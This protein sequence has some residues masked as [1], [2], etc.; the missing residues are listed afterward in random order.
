MQPIP[1]HR[2]YHA[3]ITSSDLIIPIQRPESARHLTYYVPEN[4]T[5]LLPLAQYEKVSCIV[6]LDSIAR[7]GASSCISA[8]TLV[9]EGSLWNS[10]AHMPMG[11]NAMLRSWIRSRSRRCSRA[12]SAMTS[13]LQEDC[14]RRRICRLLWDWWSQNTF[15]IMFE[16]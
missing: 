15:F 14:F 16:H 11:Y 6:L 10:R 5:H 4:I 12:V 9:K 3:F 7:M 13:D 2:T 8:Y 1:K